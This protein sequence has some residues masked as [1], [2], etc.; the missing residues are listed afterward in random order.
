[1]SICPYPVRLAT[2]SPFFLRASASPNPV[3][4]LVT[5]L[6]FFGQHGVT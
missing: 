6:R 1:M 5:E 4:E 3:Q 2:H